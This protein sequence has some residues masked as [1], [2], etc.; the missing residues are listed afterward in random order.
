MQARYEVQFEREMGCTEQELMRWLPGAVGPH[1]WQAQGQAAVICIGAGR[2]ELRWSA[3]PVRQIAL[4]RMP[5]LAV[6][7]R[8]D[9]VDD[10]SLQ[11]FMRYFD[12][13]TQRGGG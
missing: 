4:M 2:L 6:A 9:G 10:A 8:F 11:R 5:R 3:L 7:F 12:L 13:Y 1:P